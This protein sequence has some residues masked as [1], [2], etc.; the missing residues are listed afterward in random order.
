MRVEQRILAIV[1]SHPALQAIARGEPL[2][3]LQLLDLE[4]T[5]Q[6]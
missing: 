2:D 5:L 3:E 6:L 1:E 4:R